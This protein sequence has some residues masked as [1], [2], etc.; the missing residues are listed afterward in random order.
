MAIAYAAPN[1]NEKVFIG[2]IFYAWWNRT[3][4]VTFY[5]V[6]GIPNKKEVEVVEI[7]FDI[8]SERYREDGKYIGEVIPNP[9]DVLGKKFQT[10]LLLKREK[11]L[12]KKYPQFL[13][14]DNSV[15]GK[16]YAYKIHRGNDVFETTLESSS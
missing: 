11:C 14:C 10:R 3:E 6:V 4:K 15:D 7:G 8:I 13:V 2:E 5:K 9:S 1:N 16:V 12:L